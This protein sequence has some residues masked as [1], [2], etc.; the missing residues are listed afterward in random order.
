MDINASQTESFTIPATASSADKL[1]DELGGIATASEWGRSA[2]VYSRVRVQESQGRPSEKVK[3]D[4]LSPFEFARL[5]IHGL[6]S[7]TTVRRYWDAWNNAVGAGLTEAAELGRTV[8]IP[9]VPWS[10][11]YD[12]ERHGTDDLGGVSER[13]TSIIPSEPVTQPE[14]TSGT[15]SNGVL[16][17]EPITDLDRE[18]PPEPRPEPPQLAITGLGDK[19]A[20]A[21]KLKPPTPE[22]FAGKFGRALATLQSAALK[23][24]V[25]AK[26][27][28]F[29][30]WRDHLSAEHRDSVE[31]AGEIIERVLKQLT[32]DQ[33][34]MF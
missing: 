4:L 9:A 18:S 27:K 20:L 24:E 17:A 8:R 3:V 1:A 5:G 33:P 12:H 30:R 13:R 21:V 11:Y 25:L 29:G 22:G 10:C 6:R 26:D 2:I 31:W 7:K 19:Q 14:P 16:D 15:V 32:T 28:E 34:E 23:V